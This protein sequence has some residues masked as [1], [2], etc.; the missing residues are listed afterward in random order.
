MIKE[1]EVFF[2]MS[3]LLPSFKD[4]VW[5]NIKKWTM[6]VLTI[7][8]ASFVCGDGII[9][10]AISILSAL[11][12]LDWF[13]M[14]Y[15]AL[16]WYFHANSCWVFV[17]QSMGTGKLRIHLWSNCFALDARSWPNWNLQLHYSQYDYL[18]ILQSILWISLL[19]GKWCQFSSNA[20][21]CC[22]VYHRCR[23]NVFWYRTLW[24]SKCANFSHCGGLSMRDDQV[25]WTRSISIEST[26]YS[27]LPP[28]APV[29][30]N[31]LILT[32]LATIIASQAMITGTFS[33][34]TQAMTLNYFPRI[35]VK[36]TS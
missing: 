18:K 35:K 27:S 24:K 10:P 17:I 21:W 13:L 30:W 4:S 32:T 6:I 36:Q 34:L 26:F 22:I 16:W 20:W 23:S 5:G 14:I 11:E 33:L 29:F 7:I 1:K 8:L 25:Y 28:Y 31:V 15:T 3:S 19:R 2:A 12:G 9:T